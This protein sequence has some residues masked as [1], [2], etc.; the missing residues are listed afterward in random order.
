MR[1]IIILLLLGFLAFSCNSSKSLAKKGKKMEDANEYQMASEFYFQAVKKNTKNIDAIAGIRRTGSLVLNDYLNKFSKE[2]LNGNYKAAT[3]LFLDALAY[4][5]KI[6]TI[7]VD[8]PISDFQKDDFEI[9]KEEYLN[10]EYEKG[11]KFIENDE[12]RKAEH[13]FNE[14]YKFDKDFKDI[15]ELRDIAYLEPYYRKAEE[16]KN[17]QAYRKAYNNYQKI[18][19]RVPN[20]KDSKENCLYVLKKGRINLVLLT[21][22]KN[23]SFSVYTNNIKGYTESAIID[24]NDPFIKLVDRENMGSLLKEQELSISGLVNTNTAVEIGDITGA[25]YALVIEVTN[26]IF[27]ETPINKTSYKGF[28]KYTKKIY[29]KETQTTSYKTKYKPVNYYIHNG[30]KTVTITTHYKLLSLKTG[31]IIKSKIL[32][33]TKKDNIRY[34]TYS[35]DVKKLYGYDNGKVNTSYDK[36][37]QLIELSRRRQN[38]RTKA[39]LTN[40]LYKSI[41][42][43]I[44]NIIIDEFSK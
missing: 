1:N 32:N 25:Q 16:F 37:N 30:S 39:F 3:Y 33:N 2:K 9:V 14:I 11:L 44:T 10:Q 6:K 23:K 41:S 8:L 36:H 5:K 31:E 29:N 34:L 19:K 24:Q 38:L 17:N 21:S 35:G 40:D 18:L 42:G 20:Y 22:K 7:N 4:Q 13:S 26:Y 28:E 12:F 43:K 27:E 15:K